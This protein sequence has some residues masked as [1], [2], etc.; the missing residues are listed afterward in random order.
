MYNNFHMRLKDVHE[1]LSARWIQKGSLKTFKRVSIDS[2]Q[3]KKGDLFWAIHGARF[4][5]NQ[6]VQDAFE[7]GAVA[8]VITQDVQG[9]WPSHVSI[10]KIDDG[11]KA[12]QKYASVVRKQYFKQVI[13]IVGS[14]GKT[15]TKN[16]IEH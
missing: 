4:D 14:N 8:A 2:R 10:L 13:G 12:L 3:T 1:S 5:G 16:M 9:P 7:S 11:I 15:S 6:F